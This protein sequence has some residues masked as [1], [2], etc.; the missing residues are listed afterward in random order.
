MAAKAMVPV[1]ALP[2]HRPLSGPWALP[3]RVVTRQR[4]QAF[5][6]L[7]GR[8]SDLRQTHI[9]YRDQTGGAT[10]SINEKVST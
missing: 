1:E 9:D 6:A 2:W 7:A 5:F 10:P 4:C 3:T 8:R